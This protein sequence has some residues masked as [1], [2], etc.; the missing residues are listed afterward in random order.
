LKEMYCP[1]KRKMVKVNDEATV[2]YEPKTE[3]C[4]G[5][6]FNREKEGENR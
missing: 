5:C 4:K 1:H 2:C 6:F 3:E